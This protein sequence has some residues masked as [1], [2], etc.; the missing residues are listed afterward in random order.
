[1]CDTQFRELGLRLLCKLIAI[2]T[3]I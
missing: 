3:E 1:L 2:F